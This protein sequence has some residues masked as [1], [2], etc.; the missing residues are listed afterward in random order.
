M[1]APAKLSTPPLKGATALLAYELHFLYHQLGHASD[2]MQ[3][4]GK[5]GAEVRKESGFRGWLEM[6]D[7]PFD[8]QAAKEY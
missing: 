3:D 4:W 2:S 5:R 6:R 8:R 1:P 7:G